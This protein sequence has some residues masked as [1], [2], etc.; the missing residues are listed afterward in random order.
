MILDFIYEEIRKRN[1]A[2]VEG[3]KRFM[4]TDQGNFREGFR[5]TR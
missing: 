3:Y 2:D 5:R 4:A 1:P